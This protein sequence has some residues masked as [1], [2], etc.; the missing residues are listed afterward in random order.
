MKFFKKIY[1]A[2]QDH[3]IN[4]LDIKNNSNYWINCFIKNNIEYII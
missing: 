3:L 2:F 1:I 4:Y